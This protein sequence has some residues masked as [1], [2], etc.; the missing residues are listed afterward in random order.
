MQGKA[1]HQTQRAT[2]HSITSTHRDAAGERKRRK[3]WVR[4]PTG[5]RLAP[6]AEDSKGPFSGD[7]HGPAGVEEFTTAT[8]L[9]PMER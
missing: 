9:D 1:T 3:Q 8:W 5:F 6:R 4:G 7:T 2:T